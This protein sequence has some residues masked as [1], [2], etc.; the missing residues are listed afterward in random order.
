[1]EIKGR[2]PDT[3]FRRQ[4]VVRFYTILYAP[5]WLFVTVS[6][7]RARPIAGLPSTGSAYGEKEG[8]AAMIYEAG[9]SERRGKNVAFD[10]QEQYRTGCELDAPDP[11]LSA[12]A[13]IS[14]LIFG[15]VFWIVVIFYI[16]S[17]LW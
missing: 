16:F 6:Q 2:P 7:R 13:W 5:G 12:V 10:Q 1:M 11:F 14:C 8:G 17:K 3:S 9:Q 15:V 4:P